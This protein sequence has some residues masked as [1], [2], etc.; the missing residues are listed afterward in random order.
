MWDLNFGTWISHRGF[1]V[2]FGHGHPLVK[3]VVGKFFFFIVPLFSII[4]MVTINQC[5]MW[6]MIVINI[7]MVTHDMV[8]IATFL[9]LLE[10]LQ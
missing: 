10:N 5:C 8:F 6:T 7:D 2:A 4:T 9:I 3:Q 1:K